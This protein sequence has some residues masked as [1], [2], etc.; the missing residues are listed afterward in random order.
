MAESISP[1]WWMV[2]PIERVARV[3][4]RRGE[5]AALI[6]CEDFPARAADLIRSQRHIFPQ[7]TYRARLLQ[8]RFASH[9]PPFRLS[10]RAL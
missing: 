6:G 9:G 2:R 8:L 1:L 7:A 4:L 5:Y 3:L 10:E